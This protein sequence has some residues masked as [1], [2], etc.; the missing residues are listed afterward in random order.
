MSG[1]IVLAAP[2]LPVPVSASVTARSGGETGS[3]HLRINT[4]EQAHIGQGKQQVKKEKMQ[5]L[6]RLHSWRDNLI[7]LITSR[8][9]FIANKQQTW[10]YQ[11][12]GVDDLLDGY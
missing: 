7:N 9:P 3:C 10:Q 6:A 4:T 11:D 1:E 2:L 5:F 8:A 12:V